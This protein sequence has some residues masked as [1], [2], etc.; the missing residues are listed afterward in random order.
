MEKI[1]I[2]RSVDGR[3]PPGRLPTP[4]DQQ[5]NIVDHRNNTRIGCKR[6]NDERKPALHECHVNLVDQRGASS[7]V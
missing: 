3:D 6:V 1:N 2:F 7:W 4:E 5:R